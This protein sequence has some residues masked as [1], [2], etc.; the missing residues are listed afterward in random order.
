MTTPT[1]DTT[2]EVTLKG[3]TKDAVVV[4]LPAGIKGAVVADPEKCKAEIYNVVEGGVAELQDPEPLDLDMEK[5]MDAAMDD[6]YVVIHAEAIG[7]GETD[8]E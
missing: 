5:L 1:E 4:T 7:A 8:G 6:A 3:G 2:T